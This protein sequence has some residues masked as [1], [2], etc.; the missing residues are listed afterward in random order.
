MRVARVLIRS[1]V[2][3]SL[4]GSLVMGCAT[5]QVSDGGDDSYVALIRDTMATAAQSASPPK[6]SEQ[7]VR[8]VRDWREGEN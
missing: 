4:A 8:A 3:T 1:I 2:A 6:R 5:P 7:A